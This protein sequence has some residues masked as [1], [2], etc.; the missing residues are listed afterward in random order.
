MSKSQGSPG[1]QV[2]VSSDGLVSS[3]EIVKGKGRVS[4]PRP[5]V[6]TPPRPISA[7]F[8]EISNYLSQ[9][10]VKILDIVT[11]DG[12]LEDVFLQLTNS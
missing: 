12:D 1:K 6:T 2:T 10:D 5:N 8:G 4:S 3:E 11:E 7:N 9:N